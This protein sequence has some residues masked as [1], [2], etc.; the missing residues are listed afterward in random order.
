MRKKPGIFDPWRQAPPQPVEKKSALLQRDPDQ[1]EVLHAVQFMGIRAGV[2]VWISN[3]AEAERVPAA[4]LVLA[5]AV[6]KLLK[7][8][9]KE[10]LQGQGISE[11]WVDKP[12][13]VRIG[14]TPHKITVETDSA[15]D[16]TSERAIDNLA[17]ALRHVIQHYPSLE[18]FFTAARIRPFIK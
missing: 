18:H 4:R 13:A 1:L 16:R 3:K 15:G 10:Y 14:G 5:E 17:L 2:T 12:Y 11:G 7:T 6:T 8:P 9:A